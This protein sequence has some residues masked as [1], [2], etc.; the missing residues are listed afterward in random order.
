VRG[1][2]GRVGTGGIVSDC[3]LAGGVGEIEQQGR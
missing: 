1:K 3:R 2:R